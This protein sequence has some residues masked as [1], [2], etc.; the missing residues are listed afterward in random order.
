MRAQGDAARSAIVS[1]QRLLAF[2]LWFIGS[3][4]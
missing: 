4:R 1:G 3:T 2:C